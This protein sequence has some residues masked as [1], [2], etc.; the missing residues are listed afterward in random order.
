MSG[1]CPSGGTSRP[2]AIPEAAIVEG[3]EVPRP[4][5]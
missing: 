2:L 1:T 3:R 4:P 5:R